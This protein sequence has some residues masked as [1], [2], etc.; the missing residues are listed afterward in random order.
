MMKSTYSEGLKERALEKVCQRGER[1]IRSV[2][3]ELNVNYYTLKGW[4]KQ[5]MAE[6]AFGN[7]KKEKRPED[8][9]LAER[10]TALHQRVMAWW[11]RC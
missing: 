6:G 5:T 10:L 4:M 8:W 11:V 1:S 2:A 7:L 9:T 3:K